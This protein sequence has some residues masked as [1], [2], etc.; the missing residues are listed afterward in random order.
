[1]NKPSLLIVTAVMTFMIVFLPPSNKAWLYK[2]EAI[3]PENTQ[4]SSLPQMDGGK[5]H[6]GLD[7]ESISS[8]QGIQ[9]ASSSK[10][11]PSSF[12]VQAQNQ[13]G[14]AYVK[15][16]DIVKHVPIQANV[17]KKNGEIT[18]QLAQSTY[19]LL[20]DVP[21]LNKNGIHVPLAEAPMFDENDEVWLP[22]SLFQ[23]EWKQ[24]IKVNGEFAYWQ[25]DP[26][27]IPA[28]AK[29]EKV[30]K[31]SK[32]QM[33]QYLSF[34]NTPIEGAHVT[35]RASSLPGAPRTYRNG[36]H[37]GLDWYSNDTGISITKKT[38]VVSMADGIV[39]RADLG[40]EEMTTSQRNR[41][42]SIGVKNDKQTPAYILDKLRGRSVW[43]QY[44]NGVL[45]RYVHLDRVSDQIQVGQRIRTGERIGYVGNS[46]T[47]DGALGNDKGLH[48][49]LDLFI[50]GEWFW[51]DYSMDERLYILEQVFNSK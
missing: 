5:D 25:F 8:K 20:R 29:P 16:D 39:V 7:Q 45:A 46:G 32:E 51:K 21:V 42:L 41:L 40:Y 14:I 44:D 12:S 19:Q 18:L 1:M 47:S 27:I 31:L 36:V 43:V 26:N 34:L 10:P 15:L 17:D 30:S 24:N 28:S 4:E 9:V 6:P 23:Q 48:L 2:W 11:L 50:Y 13:K 35:K 22:I 49:H 38:P 3:L 37:E 33:A